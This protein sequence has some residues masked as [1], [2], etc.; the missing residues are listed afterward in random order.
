MTRLRSQFVQKKSLSVIFDLIDIKPF[1]KYVG[2][3]LQASMK[4]DIIEM[5]KSLWCRCMVLMKKEKHVL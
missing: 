2:T 5:I 3:E 4:E 1:I